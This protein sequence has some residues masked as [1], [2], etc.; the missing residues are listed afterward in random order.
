MIARTINRTHTG[1]VEEVPLT[2]ASDDAALIA[3]L[4]RGDEAAFVRLVEQYHAA[5]IRVAQVY[6]SSHAI[7]EEVAQETWLGMLQGLQRFE[8]RSSLKT[9]IFHILTNRAK[10][11]GH[12]EKRCTPFSA[13]WGVDDEASEP[14]VEPERFRATE[15]WTDHWAIPPQGWD[16]L[17]E[18]RLLSQETRAHIHASIATLPTKQRLVLTL[19]DI[20][21]L[22]SGDVCRVLGVSEV[23]QRV[24]LHRARSR[25]RAALE[26]YFN[27]V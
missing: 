1:G 6:V 13:M 8:G 26:Q 18:E 10:T 17:P 5:L 11:R 23:H 22:S 7:A 19:R 16:H 14:A 9:W 21:G 4:R 2:A 20:E 3:A 12:R 27:E 24:L 25:V 15:P